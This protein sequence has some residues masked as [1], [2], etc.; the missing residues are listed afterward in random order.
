MCAF[1]R[2]GS[3]YTELKMTLLERLSADFRFVEGLKAC[4]SCGTCTAVC[5]AAGVFD[6]DPRVLVETLQK[7]DESQLIDLLSGDFIWRCG[8][9]LSCKTRCPRGNTPGYLIQA[10]RALSIQTGYFSRSEQ[11]RMQVRILRSVG[12]HILKYGY[13]VHID[14]I[15]NDQ[16]PEQG[17]VWE[18]FREHREEILQRL[19]ANYGKEGPGVL[20]KIPDRAMEELRAIFLETGGLERFEQIEKMT[21]EIKMQGS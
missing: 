6:Y 9:C 15:D 11:G 13:C 20:R 16:F 19:G 12:E 4:M 21:G 18:W 1:I 2:K 5:P 8:E 3:V 7:R 10:L 14:E 17:P